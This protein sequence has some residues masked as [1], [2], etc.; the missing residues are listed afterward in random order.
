VGQSRNDFDIFA[1]LAA[2]LG[3]GQTYTEGRD[4][5]HWLR[6]MY[7][8]AVRE[9]APL[10]VDLPGFDEFWER[11]MFR[12]P[13]PVEAYTYLGDF[14][15]DPQQHALRTPSEKIELFSATIDAFGYDDCPPHP[16][17]IEPFEWLGSSVAA[18]YPLHMLSNQPTGRL[19]SQLDH[20]PVSRA[21]KINDREP[22]RI[23]PE[24]ALA[25]GI[26]AGD[27]VRAF[28]DRGAFLASAVLDTNL[29]RGVV[30]V[31]TGAWYD[32]LV[33]GAADSMDRHGNPNAVT[34]DQGT[35]RLAQCPTAQTTLIEVERWREPLPPITVFEPPQMAV[36]A[37]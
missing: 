19:H 1:D 29:R 6:S 25:R 28:N 14:R 23:H 17:W 4:E 5:M 2:R 18:K 21:T 16:S 27:P 3:F 8:V 35:S 34:R 30:Q 10:G 24:D 31:A 9:A 20:S 11:G 26:A 13:D 33:P 37:G 7:E 12:F 32:P 36:G 22:L 15:A